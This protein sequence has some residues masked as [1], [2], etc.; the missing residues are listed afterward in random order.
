MVLQN[1]T[2][3]ESEQVAA[4][5]RD[6]VQERDLVALATTGLSAAGGVVV[7]QEVA[8]RVATAAGLNQDPQNIKDYAGAV[9]TK[10]LVAAAFGV[11]ASSLSGLG[12]VAT[13]FMAVGALASAGADLLEALLTTAPLGGNAPLGG[14]A[15]SRS[16]GVNAS[17][18]QSSSSSTTTNATATDGGFD[19]GSAAASSGF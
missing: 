18:S 12:L 4:E 16:N 6:L 8:D 11:A 17:V 2:S 13:G 19:S 5:A 3:R 14:R 15:T 9:L 1:L 10:G 7:A